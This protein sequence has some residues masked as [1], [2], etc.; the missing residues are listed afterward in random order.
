MVGTRETSRG[1]CSGGATPVPVPVRGPDSFRVLWAGLKSAGWTAKPPSSRSLNHFWKYIK[2]G[3]DPSGKEGVDYFLGEQALLLYSREG[4][5]Y[6]ELFWLVFI[7]VASCITFVY[8]GEE[9]SR[10][11]TPARA[12][13]RRGG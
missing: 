8:S 7:D 3:G 6:F 9:K 2:P 11:S 5:P 13:N 4:L 1:S 10:S 12:T